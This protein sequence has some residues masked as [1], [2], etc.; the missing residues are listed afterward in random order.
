MSTNRTST[1]APSSHAKRMWVVEG[2]DGANSVL[3]SAKVPFGRY[4]ERQM[5]DLLRLLVA[6]AELTFDEILAST[7]RR[8]SSRAALLNVH[9]QMQPYGLSCGCGRWF[10]ARVE[11]V[12]GSA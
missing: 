11:S 8:R 6:R 3:W 5:E 7:G 4:S 9:H 1:N 12:D 2:R 10:T